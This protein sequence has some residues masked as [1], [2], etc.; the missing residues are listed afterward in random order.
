MVNTIENKSSNFVGCFNSMK[1]T[2]QFIFSQK[3]DEQKFIKKNFEQKLLISTVMDKQQQSLECTS[4]KKNLK[5]LKV[6]KMQ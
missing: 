5:H 3:Y 4:C 2:N 1:Y 6:D